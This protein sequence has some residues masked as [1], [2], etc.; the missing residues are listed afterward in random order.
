MAR[1]AVVPETI[2]YPDSDGL[3]MAENE[4]QFWRHRKVCTQ[5]YSKHGKHDC[6]G[7]RFCGLYA[8]ILAA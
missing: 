7:R 6:F 1:V 3:P 2:D 8:G 4:F 5:N